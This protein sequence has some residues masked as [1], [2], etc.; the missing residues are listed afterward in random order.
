MSHSLALG[1]TCTNVF[2]PLAGEFAR[3]RESLDTCIPKAHMMTLAVEGYDL[4]YI[5]G[6]GGTFSSLMKQSYF[7]T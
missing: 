2:Y 4:C 3:K 1:L 6:F 7:P 5:L